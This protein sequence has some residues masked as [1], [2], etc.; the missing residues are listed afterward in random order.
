M[1]DYFVALDQLCQCQVV[2]ENTHCTERSYE[3]IQTSQ[4][5][6][7]PTEIIHYQ[8]KANKRF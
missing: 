1:E 2:H 5:T 6:A 8:N 3:C 7:D 4:F